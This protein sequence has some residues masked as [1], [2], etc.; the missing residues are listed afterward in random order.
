[1]VGCDKGKVA[2]SQGLQGGEKQCVGSKSLWRNA[3]TALSPTREV[4]TAE[5]GVPTV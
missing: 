5:V 2:V 1:M 4:F 3:L